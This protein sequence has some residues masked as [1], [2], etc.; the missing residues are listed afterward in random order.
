MRKQENG[1]GCGAVPRFSGNTTGGKKKQRKGKMVQE[2]GKDQDDHVLSRPRNSAE[3]GI[4]ISLSYPGLKKI[5]K[6]Q[7]RSKKRKNRKNTSGAVGAGFCK[8]QMRERWRRRECRQDLLK[9][10]GIVVRSGEEG[11]E[12]R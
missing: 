11:A 12:K 4:P 9:G 3:T 6:G 5:R 1:G 8:S 2:E 10:K 7:G